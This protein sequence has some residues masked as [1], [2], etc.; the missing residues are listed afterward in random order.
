MAGLALYE[1]HDV[2][3]VLKSKEWIRGYYSPADGSL[4]T[5]GEYN[6]SLPNWKYYYLPWHKPPFAS[7]RTDGAASNWGNQIGYLFKCFPDA[8][9]LN[10]NLEYLMIGSTNRKGTVI[11]P[12]EGFIYAYISH[13][14]KVV[15]STENQSYYCIMLAFYDE[16]D[17]FIRSVYA[18]WST[19]ARAM[20]FTDETVQSWISQGACV[21]A[22]GLSWNTI[23]NGDIRR[24]NYVK[25]K[26]QDEEYFADNADQ[27]TQD[28]FRL[29]GT[30]ENS[31]ID[32]H[33]AKKIR[34]SVGEMFTGFK[35]NIWDQIVYLDNEKD[36]NNLMVDPAPLTVAELTTRGSVSYLGQ[37][38]YF[39]AYT[40]NDSP[41]PPDAEAVKQNEYIIVYDMCEPQNGFKS[42]GL[43]VLT[44]S[45]CEITE[46]LNGGY[47]INL[48]HPYDTEGRYRYL[49]DWNIIKVRGQ[50]FRIRRVSNSFRGN[51]GKI[52]IYAEHIFYDLSDE[53]IMQAGR[54]YTSVHNDIG[55]AFSRTARRTDPDVPQDGVTYS[56]GYSSDAEIDKEIAP[57]HW[58]F[59]KD[60]TLLDLIIGSDGFMSFTEKPSYLY[61]DNFYFSI[62]YEMENMIKQAFDIR[63]GLNAKGIT[64]NVDVS[65]FA[66]FFK[67]YDS[68]GNW[69]W[70]KWIATDG[71]FPHA[72][73][74]SEEFEHDKDDYS[75][76]M[77]LLEKQATN[78]FFSHLTPEV[79]YV[80]DFEDIRYSNDYSGI[81]IDMRFKVGDKG[82]IID[83]RMGFEATYSERDAHEYEISK[84]VIDGITGKILQVQFGSARNFTH[85]RTYD[86]SI[87]AGSLKLADTS[88]RATVRT[89]LDDEVFTNTDEAV[90]VFILGKLA[91]Y[92]T[93]EEVN[94][95]L[96]DGKTAA[97][98]V[99]IIK[100]EILG[101][102][103]LVG[104]GIE[105]DT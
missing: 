69:F 14:E 5:T 78:F 37:D 71:D 40:S 30:Y 11:Y 59:K 55:I 21:P 93:V 94:S 43:A 82:R 18:H 1:K 105:N 92:D 79:V 101:I 29:G 96:N 74:R 22:E 42:N 36:L 53:W 52:S 68:L 67:A 97:A 91:D 46:E 7:Y 8:I 51:S 41:V 17:K 47:Y 60:L 9:D 31:Y 61:R 64:R 90:E 6:P 3:S 75:D 56:F 88:A 20:S 28:L 98:D 57:Y 50:L 81:D 16:N 58:D 83:E 35:Y 72:I 65:T 100:A 49:V 73:V 103:T 63:V 76:H 87:D 33:N 85:P 99:E 89:A 27:N 54:Y 80:I 45:K 13:D 66:S 10:G 24:I 48:E 4:V 34:V 39:K 15:E 62:N 102:N 84:T 26:T 32:L 19:N 70:W 95:A 23:N 77:K 38:F 12:S 44:P 104:E 2:D 25:L 86:Y